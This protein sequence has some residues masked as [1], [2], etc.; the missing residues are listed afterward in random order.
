MADEKIECSECEGDGL[1]RTPHG[2]F[3]NDDCPN[4]DGEGTVRI[5]YD[6]KQSE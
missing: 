6:F 5:Q 3:S 1:A 4:C 2:Y